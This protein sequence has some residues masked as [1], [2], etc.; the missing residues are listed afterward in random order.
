MAK[1]V[2]LLLLLL[3]AG[4]I[5]AQES[6]PPDYVVISLVGDSL[7]VARKG[8]DVRR[9][10]HRPLVVPIED[11]AL[12]RAALVATK[13]AIERMDPGARVA[14]SV[15]HEP[16]VYAAQSQVLGLTNDTRALL[17]A[18]E[19]V[20][21]RVRARRLILLSKIRHEPKTDFADVNVEYPGLLEG[22]GFFIDPARRVVDTRTM[23]T[24][25]GYFSV[26]AYFRATMVDLGTGNIIAEERVVAA[27]AVRDAAKQEPWDSMSAAAK[28]A[29]MKAV[30][31]GQ[32]AT[33]LPRLIA[34]GR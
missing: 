30:L 24:T 23:Q 32:I 27:P 7:T 29:A 26:F 8:D 16:M 13:N 33:V 31:T 28:V 15:V 2:A 5:R 17:D 3:S 9:E 21:K 18:L 10:G 4:S 11:S 19:P 6:A 14:M 22:I 1:L 12:D 20:T 25:Y 34:A